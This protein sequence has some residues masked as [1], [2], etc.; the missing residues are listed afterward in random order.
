MATRSAEP[1]IRPPQQA[2]SR[3]ALQKLLTA[4]EDVLIN[5]GLDEFTI[6]AV[7]AQAGVSVGGLYRRFAG[8]EQ[9]IEA[10]IE[11]LLARLEDTVAEALSA[12]EPSL[13]G[14]IN[15]FTH[16][17]A[18]SL[19]RTGRVAS[20]LVGMQHT[21]EMQQRGLRAL[22]VLQR[23][24]LDAAAPYTHQIARTAQSTA[25][26]TTLRTI[27]GAGVHRAAV[28]QRWPDGVSWT[29]WADEITD[30]ATTY[31]STPSDRSPAT[32]RPRRRPPSKGRTA[33]RSRV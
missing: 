23:L 10:V 29:Q 9:L 22:T 15:A 20:A 1:Q 21:P 28:A 32:V 12:A 26:T 4:A 3:A 17:L 11:G 27:I 24:F 33:A 30:M 14:V 5:Q 6:A 2:R 16:A 31:L 19:T 7:A 8:K 18:S 25:L 13:A